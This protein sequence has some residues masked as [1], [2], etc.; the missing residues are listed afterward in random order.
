MLLLGEQLKLVMAIHLN[1]FVENIAKFVSKDEEVEHRPNMASLTGVDQIGYL[2]P[3][4]ND[5][6]DILI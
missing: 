3:K 2:T 5:S 4:K 1:V 6:K